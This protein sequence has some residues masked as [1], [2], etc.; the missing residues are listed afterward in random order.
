LRSPA[1]WAGL[2]ALVA[3]ALYYVLIGAASGVDS[4]ERE[5]SVA[6]VKGSQRVPSSSV[7]RLRVRVIEEYA[8]DPSAYTQGLLWDDGWILEST[9]QYGSSV[10]RK[11]RPGSTES[12]QTELAQDLFG[13]GLARVGDR[14]IQLT[15]R[16][17]RALLYDRHSLERVGEWEYQGE[18]WGLCFDGVRLAMSDGSSTLTFRDPGTFAVVDRTE[19]QLEGRSVGNLNELECAEGWIYANVYQTNE[20]VRIDPRSGEVTAII[21][22]GGL[23]KP[24][25]RSNAEVLNGIAYDPE[26]ESFLLTGKY[27]PKIFRVTLERE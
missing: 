9:G 6:G 3:A 16:A 27:W 1:L 12:R 2:A 14:L 25:E 20:I 7:E 19:V 11:W 17:G 21:N 15:W 22:A 4:G 24:Q 23:L 18:G 10:V 26:S 5:A 8:H 13:E